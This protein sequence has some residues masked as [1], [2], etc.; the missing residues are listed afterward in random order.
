MYLYGRS[1]FGSLP[2]EIWQLSALKTLDL[3]KCEQLGSVPAKI[4]QLTALQT[5]R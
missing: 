5:K 2:T 4:G 1:E 3:S